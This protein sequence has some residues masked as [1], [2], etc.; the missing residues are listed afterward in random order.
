MA[1]DVA[2]PA[3]NS[4]DELFVAGWVRTKPFQIWLG[5]GQNAA[6]DLVYS[7]GKSEMSFQLAIASSDKSVT[8]ELAIYSSSLSRSVAI[9]E[10]NGKSIGRVDL[11]NGY[12]Y[13]GL[14]DG[15]RLRFVSVPEPATFRLM[16]IAGIA[17][18]GAIRCSTIHCSV[19][20]NVAL[21]CR[22]LLP[23]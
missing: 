1:G 3:L 7:L 11:S 9:V 17:C 4:Q 14:A 19:R 18:L 23:C 15:D 8:G 10:L 16:G 5:D 20:N 2:P 13:S 21:R 12:K 6:G 22:P